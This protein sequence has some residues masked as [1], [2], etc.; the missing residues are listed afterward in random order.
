VRT[1]VDG[2]DGFE[3]LEV[4]V[5]DGAPVAGHTLDEVRLPEGGL[6]VSGR[7]RAGLADSGTE[8]VAGERYVV[9]VEAA[10]VDEVLNL[11]GE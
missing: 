1:L 8:L 2:R 11:F 9:A 5:A 6:V 10:V 3:I 7:G 4:A